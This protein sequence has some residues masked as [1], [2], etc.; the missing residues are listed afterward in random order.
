MKA[1]STFRPTTILLFRITQRN[2]SRKLHVFQRHYSDTQ[3]TSEWRLAVAVMSGN[4][5]V[6]LYNTSIGSQIL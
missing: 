1:K 5:T 6:L 4:D 2:I 3:N